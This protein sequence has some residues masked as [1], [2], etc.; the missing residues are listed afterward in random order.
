[1]VLTD[2]VGT[3]IANGQN[4]VASVDFDWYGMGVAYADWMAENYPGERFVVLTGFFDSPPSQKINQGMTERAEELGVNELVTIEETKY[5][6]DTAVSLAQD[7]INSGEEF[8]L[9]FVMDEDMSTAVIRMLRNDG[10]LDNPIKVFAQNG[11]PAG[12]PLLEEGS[13]KYT[14]SSS[15]GW[16][17]FVAYHALNNFVQGCT[18]ATNQQIM[19]PVIPVTPENVSDPMQVVPWEPSDVYWDVTNQYLPDLLAGRE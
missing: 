19:L 11:S 10:Y 6:P 14:I 5:S 3:V 2:S 17:G 13:L 1:M 16:E 7:L 4:H 18:D 9:L 8:G 15:P 12:I